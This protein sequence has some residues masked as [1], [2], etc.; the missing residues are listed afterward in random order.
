MQTTQ[1]AARTCK[2]CA[3]AGE[4][5]ANGSSSKSAAAAAR[6][7]QQMAAWQQTGRTK[8]EGEENNKENPKEEL[9]SL[10]QKFM[11]PTPDIT[12]QRDFMGFDVGTRSEGKIVPILLTV[13][14]N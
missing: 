8:K 11:V 6:A 7:K 2:Q 12:Y 14:V 13:E 1:P 10:L 3:P 9:L 4:S 5:K